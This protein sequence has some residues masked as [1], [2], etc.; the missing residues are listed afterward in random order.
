MAHI[1]VSRFAHLQQPSHL[2]LVE[3]VENGVQEDVAGG[4]ACRADGRP[5]PVVVLRCWGSNREKLKYFKRTTILST[6]T[7]KDLLTNRRRTV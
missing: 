5:L 2:C 1:Y 3:E 4:G 7:I 6:I